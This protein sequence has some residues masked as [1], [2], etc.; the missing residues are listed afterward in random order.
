[1]FFLYIFRVA[2]YKEEGKRVDSSIKIILKFDS[3]ETVQF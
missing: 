1:M 2:V 3:N